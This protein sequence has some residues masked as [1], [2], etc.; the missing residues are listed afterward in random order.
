MSTG[1]L[2]L[3]HRIYDIILQ[4]LALTLT[5]ATKQLI[6]EKIM[7][8]LVVVGYDDIYKAEEVRLQL[9]KLQR[10]YLTGSGR[11]R[12]LCQGRQG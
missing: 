4:L 9:W 12:R 8:T 10:D 7:S 5:I 6:K 1:L 3:D 11:C 2:D